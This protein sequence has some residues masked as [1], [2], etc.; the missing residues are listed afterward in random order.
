MKA[1]DR[2]INKLMIPGIAIAIVLIFVAGVVTTNTFVA[3]V[4]TG[5]FVLALLVVALA[6]FLGGPVK[7]L[8]IRKR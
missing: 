4:V 7:T 2:A 3:T 6:L 5:A 8:A 1:F